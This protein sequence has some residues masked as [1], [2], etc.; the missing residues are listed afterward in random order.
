MLFMIQ[1]FFDQISPSLLWP[2]F[3]AYYL[4]YKGNTPRY[5]RICRTFSEFNLVLNTFR[6]A[7]FMS[8]IAIGKKKKKKK[9]EFICLMWALI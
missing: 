9:K 3:V 2:V 5:V 7:K 1:N 8:A 6:F 4:L